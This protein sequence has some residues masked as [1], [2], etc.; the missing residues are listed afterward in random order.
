MKNDRNPWAGKMDKPGKLT[1]EQEKYICSNEM[2][3]NWAPLSLE[4][5]CNEI[6]N[7]M[8]VE[9]SRTTLAKV[10]K[11]NDISNTKPKFE[12]AHRKNA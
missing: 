1:P 6:W 11:S 4:R 5:R 3:L 8:G 7:E 10:Y 12:Y 2:L 9:I